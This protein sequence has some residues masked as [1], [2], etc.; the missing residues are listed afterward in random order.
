MLMNKSGSTGSQE[1]KEGL[2]GE[3]GVSGFF[4]CFSE[5]PKPPV[6]PDYSPRC[7]TYCLN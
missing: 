4:F 1:R 3:G 5:V 6:L 2:A 7:C